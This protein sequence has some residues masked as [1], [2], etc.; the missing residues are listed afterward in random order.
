MEEGT[1][2]SR[3]SLIF[4]RKT[5]LLKDLSSDSKDLEQAMS[6]PITRSYGVYQGRCVSILYKWIFCFEWNNTIRTKVA[7]ALLNGEFC[8]IF[9]PS[10]DCCFCIYLL[11]L[12]ITQRYLHRKSVDTGESSIT[13]FYLFSIILH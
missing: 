4:E 9:R 6:L 5:L 10:L 1:L 3:E 2:G 12:D 7:K 13:E 8:K 11:Q